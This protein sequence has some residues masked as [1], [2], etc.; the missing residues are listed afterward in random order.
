MTNIEIPTRENFTL[1]KVKM[2][3]DGGVFAEYEVAVVVNGVASIRKQKTERN[4]LAH[5]DLKNSFEVL[6]P[7]VLRTFGLTSFLSIVDS[8]DFGATE[9]QSSAMYKYANDLHLRTSIKGITI[10]E[11][12]ESDGV[13]ITSM[14]GVLN[15]E[16]SSVLNTPKITLGDETYGFETELLSAVD[17]I[18]EEV[19]QY[20]FEGKQSQ[21]SLFNGNSESSEEESEEPDLFD[22]N[23]DNK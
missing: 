9:K 6:K 8:K 14:L 4:D 21:L 15:T 17:T 13:I 12:K 20:L 16:Q 2:L 5:P 10:K 11:G 19:Y 23:A 7:F 22:V 18:Q 3:K 1:N